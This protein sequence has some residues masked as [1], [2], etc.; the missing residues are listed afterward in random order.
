MIIID[1]KSAANPTFVAWKASDQ[2]AIILLQAHLSE[3]AFSEI[4]GLS[5]IREIWLALESAYNNSSV[6]CI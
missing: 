4:V 5:S 1:G 2:R 6:E 3:E